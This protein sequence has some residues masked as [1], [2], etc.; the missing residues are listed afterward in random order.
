MRVAMLVDRK[1][2]DARQF[3][4]SL[5]LGN[6]DNSGVPAG[7]IEKKKLKIYSGSGRIK[8]LAREAVDELVSTER[9]IFG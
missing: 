9:L 8:G 3:A 1:A 5:L 4:K 7:L 2:T 6:G